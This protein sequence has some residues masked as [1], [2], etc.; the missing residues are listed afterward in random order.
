MGAVHQVENLKDILRLDTH[1]DETIT[2]YLYIFSKNNFLRNN[3][4]YEK[5]IFEKYI[6]YS[7]NIYKYIFNLLYKKYILH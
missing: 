1:N 7:K 6:L 3:A 5:N 4:L 2:K